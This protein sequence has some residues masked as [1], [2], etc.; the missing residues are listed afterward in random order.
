MQLFELLRYEEFFAL[1]HVADTK[2]S[3]KTSLVK[4]LWCSEMGNKD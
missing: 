2:F 4:L 3:G 1:H